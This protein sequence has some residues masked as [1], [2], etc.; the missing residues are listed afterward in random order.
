[1]LTDKQERFVQELITGKSQREAYKA[2]YAAERM[3][4]ETIDK[5]ACELMKNRKIAGRYEELQTAV[6][7]ESAQRA[8]ATAAEVLEELTAIGMGEKEYPSYDM[9]GKESPRKPSMTARLKALELL[10]KHHSLFADKVE[11]S[12]EI[13]VTFSGEGVDFAK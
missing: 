13:K 2:A 10:A 11:Q 4:D 1:M 12:G 8:V 6:R 9:F 5:R 3:K 7:A